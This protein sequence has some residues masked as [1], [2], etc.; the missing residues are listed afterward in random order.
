MTAGEWFDPIGQEWRTTA[1]IVGR[2]AR[3]KEAARKDLERVVG[4]ET[5]SGGYSYWDGEHWNVYII[6]PW[7]RVPG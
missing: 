2:E 7:H 1:F 5:S 6:T 4:H 3:L